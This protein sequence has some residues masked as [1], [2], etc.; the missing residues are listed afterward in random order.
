MSDAVRT[1]IGIVEEVVMGTTPA[2]PAF[3]TL[4]VTIPNL[5]GSKSTKV[6][7]ELAAD[8]RIKDRITVGFQSGGDIGQEVS[9][10]A[11]DT[12]IR[13]SMFSE[14]NWAPVRNNNG[15]AD[16]IIT[17]VTATDVTVLASN[18]TQF[19]AGVFAPGHLVRTSG[20]TNAGNNALR[21]AG[22]GTID[23]DLKLAGGTIEG[24]PPG[25]ARAK[26]IGFQG[27]AGDIT[28]TAGG[29]G[30]TALDFTTLGLVAGMWLWVGGTTAATFFAT[31]GVGGWC[32]IGVGGIA[33]TALT[34]DVKP[35]TWGV[36]AGA[37]KTISVF[38]GDYIREGTTKRT[39]TVEQQFQDLVIP[40]FEYYRG[41]VP[42]MFELDVKQQDIM[43]CKTTFMG[44]TI[45][46]PNAV[47]FAGATDVAAPTNDV[48]NT[49]DN[50]GSVLVNGALLAGNYLTSL[51]LTIDN[52]GRRNNAIGSRY[53]V[54][55]KGGRA[56]INGKLEMYYDDQTILAFIRNSTA[57]GLFLPVLDPTGTKALLFDTPRVKLGDGSPTVPGIDTD[58]M[59]P[60]DF[61]ALKHP[62]LGYELQIQRLEEFNV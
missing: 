51:T 43:T 1:Q 54:N 25:T 8:R 11:Q 38:F 7:N 4:R 21:R 50:V 42:T 14:W 32:R 29:L 39:Y 56:N 55:V 59:L 3:E 26:V 12:L 62:A 16:S 45:A 37:A 44:L 58:R 27:V 2:T 19:R 13:G 48:I 24:A 10:G 9:Y 35:A 47:R 28:A 41:M 53:S 30:S 18:G 17:D 15:T 23:T 61:Q 6:S 33:A 46:D 20:F 57:I 60:T 49:S 34:F 5:A 40:T 31:A 52:N 36:D 22:A